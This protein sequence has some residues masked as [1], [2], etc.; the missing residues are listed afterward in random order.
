MH[1]IWRAKDA[2]ARPQN[3][4]TRRGGRI[5]SPK[6]RQV[7]RG[8]SADTSRAPPAENAPAESCEISREGRFELS[9]RLG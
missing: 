1:E 6:R 8:P 9:L 3:G 5:P 2:P 7:I 4:L